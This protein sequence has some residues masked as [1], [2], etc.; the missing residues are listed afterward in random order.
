MFLSTLLFCAMF[1]SVN[2]DWNVQ[3]ARLFSCIDSLKNWSK[4]LITKSHNEEKVIGKRRTHHTTQGIYYNLFSFL[5]F[6]FFFLE[7]KQ[8]SFH[9]QNIYWSL[10][11]KKIPNHHLLY[12]FILRFLLLCRNFMLTHQAHIHVQ[13]V[14]PNICA[15]TWKG[16]RYHCKQHKRTNTQC[17]HIHVYT[18]HN[19]IQRCVF[20][21]DKRR[22]DNDN[23]LIVRS[24]SASQ[25]IVAQQIVVSR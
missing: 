14:Y 13:R 20:N 12:D 16:E 22:H 11:S 10:C 1:W 9:F 24:L 4:K 15:H 25:T 8:H 3:K 23:R 2:I 6:L 7:N 18:Q 17:M 5:E 19:H 21:D